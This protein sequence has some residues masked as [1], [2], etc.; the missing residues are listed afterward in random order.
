MAPEEPVQTQLL[1]LWRQDKNFQLSVLDKHGEYF[2]WCKYRIKFD[3]V[4]LGY[5]TKNPT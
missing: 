2:I 1:Q 3:E 4:G 5:R